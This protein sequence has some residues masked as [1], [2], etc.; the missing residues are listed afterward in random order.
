[1]TTTIF[2]MLLFTF[3]TV[4]GLITEVIKKLIIE[5]DKLSYNLTALITALI[6]SSMG[7]I[8][9]YQ[10]NAIPFIINNIIHILLIGIASGLGSMIGYDKIS[11]LISQFTTRE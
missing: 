10:L 1:M 6:V 2:L 8:I 11:Q 5:K 3:S 9:Y 7:T 4:S